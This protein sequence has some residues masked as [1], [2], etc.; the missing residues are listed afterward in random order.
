MWN[1]A[2]ISISGVICVTELG[3]SEGWV[4]AQPL[5]YISQE[6]FPNKNPRN[7]SNA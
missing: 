5:K 4:R 1:D 6:V 2:N 7:A 3:L